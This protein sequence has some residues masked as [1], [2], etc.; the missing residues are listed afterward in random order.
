MAE[1]TITVVVPGNVNPEYVRQHAQ[2]HMRG[3]LDD[4]SRQAAREIAFEDALESDDGLAAWISG[5]WLNTSAVV[6]ASTYGS[7]ID[8]YQELWP[9]NWRSDPRRPVLMR[10]SKAAIRGHQKTDVYWCERVV[11][12]YFRRIKY[13]CVD[14]D[15]HIAYANNIER[16]LGTDHYL[17]RNFDIAYGW[18]WFVGESHLSGS[19]GVW[20]DGKH[21]S[22]LTKEQLST[23]R[24]LGRGLKL[25][26]AA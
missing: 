5:A 1:V 7:K 21:C 6:R 16:N 3:W 13:T 17:W 25:A 15:E 22:G 9:F 12:R 19:I 4:L 8:H 10:G 23:L 18:E 14:R 24:A 2:E 11:A 26:E 20:I